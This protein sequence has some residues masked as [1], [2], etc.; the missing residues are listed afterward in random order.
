MEEG[1]G[2]GR[3]ETAMTDSYDKVFAEGVNSVSGEKRN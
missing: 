3:E 2:H 1:K